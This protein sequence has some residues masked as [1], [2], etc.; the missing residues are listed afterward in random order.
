MDKNRVPAGEPFP[1]E[2]IVSATPEG[3]EAFRDQSAVLEAAALIRQM[4]EAAGLTQ[5]GLARLVGTSQPHLSELERG[6]GTQ[7]PT[8]L[9]LRKIAK[10]CGTT[11]RMEIG[12]RNEGA[13]VPQA[14]ENASEQVRIEVVGAFMSVTDSTEVYTKAGMVPPGV[15]KS[16]NV[17]TGECEVTANGAVYITTGSMDDFSPAA[18]AHNDALN[19]L[20]EARTQLSNPLTRMY[21]MS[22]AENLITKALNDPALLHTLATEPWYSPDHMRMCAAN[23]SGEFLPYTGK[24]RA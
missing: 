21:G 4:R 8:F 18:M 20:L 16:G 9:M 14:A 5:R 6:T 23:E 19:K 3:A 11:L 10:A 24:T 2:E 1:I 12:G 22:C 15:Y 17:L 7:G 13:G